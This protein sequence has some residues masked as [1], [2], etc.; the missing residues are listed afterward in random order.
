MV[1]EVEVLN[2]GGT[3]AGTAV[4]TSRLRA[5][6]GLSLGNR[7]YDGQGAQGTLVF[8]DDDGEYGNQQDLP[9]GLTLL[10]VA[11]HNVITVV[12]TATTAPT[13]LLNGRVGQK[14][15]GRGEL[16]QDRSRQVR[17]TLEDSN[18]H[19]RGITLT[20]DEA[21]GSESDVTRVTWVLTTYLQGSPRLT[22]DLASRVINSDTVT[23]PA[24]TY[25][26][27][28]PIIDIIRDCATAAGK[29]FFVYNEGDGT[30]SLYYAVNSDTSLLAGIQISDR[31]DEINTDGSSASAV[32][33]P[34]IPTPNGDWESGDD[35][36]W[37]T[38]PVVAGDPSGSG[39]S[40]YGSTNTLSPGVRYD[41]WLGD[42]FTAGLTYVVR[43][44]FTAPNHPLIARFGDPAAGDFTDTVVGGSISGQF[45]TVQW[46]PSAN[47]TA[48]SIHFQLGET[49]TAL[50]S[51]EI[52]LDVMLLLDPGAAFTFPPIW[53]GPASVENGLG[54]LSGGVLR[55]GGGAATSNDTA[56]V[57]SYDYWVEPINDIQAVDGTDA[58][59][60]LAK[61]LALRNTEDRTYT[62]AVRL[63]RTQVNLVHAGDLINIKAYA[64][65]DADDQFRQ[66]RIASLEWQWAGP[67]HYIAIMELDRPLVGV[68][69]PGSS[70]T[71]KAEV[72]A[73]QRADAAVTAHEGAADP[74][75]GYVLESLVDAKGDVLTAS[76]DNTPAR[77]AVGTDG[78][79]LK[80]NSAT[81]TGL[82]W[83]ANSAGALDDLT[84]V[85]IA[86]PGDGQV[87][88]YDSAT[89]EWKNENSAAGFSN[90]MTAAGDIIK[91]GAA[92]AAER[93]AIG[94]AGQ[95][96][97]V[98][99]GATAPE[100]A[101]AAAGGSESLPL[102]TISSY[103][104]GD[105]FAGT[106]LDGGW[107][108]LQATALTTVD[109]SI[110]GYLILG[111]SGAIGAN[112]QRGIDRAFSPAGDFTVWTK[113][114]WSKIGGN[115][116]GFTLFFGATDPSDAAGG[117]RTQIFCYYN[118]T[119]LKYEFA[120][121][122]AGAVT[123]HATAD[124]SATPTWMRADK[125]PVWLALRRVGT[126]VSFGISQD[127]VE[128]TWHTTTTTISF[129]VA[130]CG[131]AINSHTTT[132][133]PRSIFDYIATEG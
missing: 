72:T 63:H 40:W 49:W 18:S 130:T 127:G 91:G 95:V 39:G 109:A 46:T 64:I 43:F 24:K 115:Y 89:S 62:V 66:R 124:V 12:E 94:T 38:F 25:E 110:D 14:A 7:A 133:P 22:T 106:T 75:A 117:N 123:S 4:L 50:E 27:G 119:T 30:L 102:D 103:G 129:T 35:T 92:G 21:R 90:P 44:W 23:M 93:L 11:A 20:S 3:A 100:W 16:W 57:D 118:G 97:T 26:A 32:A 47:R 19:L 68:G 61:I 54:L 5:D 86:A 6:L 111:N 128:F 80:A 131:L 48:A 77:L 2:G 45:A 132:T 73:Q 58:S 15:I 41:G 52:S 1:L 87:L 96:L 114:V 108:S 88:T 42:T 82:E 10:S 107:S 113:V 70:G 51:G 104:S 69:N 56:V 65:P 99:A 13:Y 126:A 33:H 122:A 125:L 79:V 98:N 85:V 105:S 78:Q 67:E 74:H 37:T 84:D 76:A 71:A 28:T 17:T 60:R 55:H 81:A 31:P 112:V 121:V 36:N 29:V 101:T 83:A 116:M 53:S 120:T 8:D 9:A 34:T 59:A